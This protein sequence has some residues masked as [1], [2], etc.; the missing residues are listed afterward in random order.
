MPKQDP[1]KTTVSETERLKAEIL[2][3]RRVKEILDENERKRSAYDRWSRQSHKVNMNLPYENHHGQLAGNYSHRIRGGLIIQSPPEQGGRQVYAIRRP[4]GGV[5]SDPY[6]IFRL[7]NGFL[8]YIPEGLP[9]GV[10]GNPP[11]VFAEADG[12]ERGWGKP[13]HQKRK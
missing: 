13:K 6:T 2:H 8:R 12:E 11:P 7:K 4:H 5:E 3:N 1:N 10:A 9:G